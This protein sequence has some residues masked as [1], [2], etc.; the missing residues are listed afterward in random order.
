MLLRLPCL[1]FLVITSRCVDYMV[2]WYNLKGWFIARWSEMKSWKRLHSCGIYLHGGAHEQE[3]QHCINMDLSV[4]EALTRYGAVH[5]FL[6]A[7]ETSSSDVRCV[8]HG[9][10]KGQCRFQMYDMKM[11]N[12]YVPHLPGN[13]S[14]LHGPEQAQNIQDVFLSFGLVLLPSEVI[15]V[16]F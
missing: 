3:G 8:R 16:T 13:T 5:H 7:S 6:S 14:A 1:F 11:R 15:D 10:H 9:A 12:F 2:D 4:T